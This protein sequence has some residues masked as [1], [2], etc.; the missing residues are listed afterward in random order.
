MQPYD[1]AGVLFLSGENC[2]QQKDKFALK[3]LVDGPCVSNVCGV[4]NPDAGSDRV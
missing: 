2:G 3:L 4:F 1:K